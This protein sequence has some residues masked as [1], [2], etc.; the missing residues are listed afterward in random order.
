MASKWHCLSPWILHRVPNRASSRPTMWFYPRLDTVNRKTVKTQSTAPPC[1]RMHVDY[2][3]SVQW[4]L[5][6]VWLWLS[7]QNDSIEGI[8]DTLKECAAI[9]KSAGGI[10]LHIHNIRTVG[11]YIRGTNGTSNG[12]VPMLRV[13]NDTARYSPSLEQQLSATLSTASPAAA[14]LIPECDKQHLII[15]SWCLDLERHR[16]LWSCV[17]HLPGQIVSRIINHTDRVCNICQFSA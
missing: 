9:S 6:C 17:A 11:S 14:I 15:G 12:I 7:V 1:H 16:F 4:Y 8:Y 10:G 2:L 13:F 5:T 3:L